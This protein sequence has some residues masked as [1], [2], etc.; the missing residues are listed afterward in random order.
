[1]TF[2]NFWA[3][4]TCPYHRFHRHFLKSHLKKDPKAYF[5][6]THLS[7]APSFD[8]SEGVSLGQ[9]KSG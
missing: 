4:H 5:W 8:P 7:M 2:F 9:T 3:G 6:V 1:L